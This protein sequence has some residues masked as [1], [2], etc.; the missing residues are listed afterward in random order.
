MRRS[1]ALRRR[2]A[3]RLGG[4]CGST[5]FCLVYLLQPDRHRDRHAAA[6]NVPCDTRRVLKLASPAGFEPA[7]FRL[8]GWDIRARFRRED[9]YGDSYAPIR[10]GVRVAA[11]KALATD[12]ERERVRPC[13]RAA[14]RCRG[15]DGLGPASVAR[16]SAVMPAPDLCA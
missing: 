5:T 2:A 16:E 15:A 12:D 7:T 13:P 10:L 6:P 11:K 8:E 4:P 14:A 1:S 3:P 9:S